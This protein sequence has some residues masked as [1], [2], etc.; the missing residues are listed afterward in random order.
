MSFYEILDE[1]GRGFYDPAEMMT[2]A[3]GSGRTRKVSQSLGR[4]MDLLTE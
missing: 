2:Q 4:K 1:S 3:R